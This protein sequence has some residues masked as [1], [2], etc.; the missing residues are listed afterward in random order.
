MNKNNNKIENKNFNRA[1]LDGG[2]RAIAAEYFTYFTYTYFTYFIVPI[3][4]TIRIV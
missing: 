1:W 2:T 3:L 4:R